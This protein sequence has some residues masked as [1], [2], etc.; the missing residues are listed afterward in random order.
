M[1][2][3]K[4]VTKDHV[5]YDSIYKECPEQANLDRK[6]YISGCPGLGVVPG[7]VGDAG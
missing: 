5:L 3:N 4:K 1:K 2:V 7:G 6:K